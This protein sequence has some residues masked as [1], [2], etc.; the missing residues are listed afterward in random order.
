MVN[1]SRSTRGRHR[2]DRN[3][4]LTRTRDRE[5]T[6]SPKGRSSKDTKDAKDKVRH[7]IKKTKRKLIY[8]LF[9]YVLNKFNK[10]K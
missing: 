8:K 2:S 4:I 9:S 5:A 7:I 3:F 6:A 10:K 1:N